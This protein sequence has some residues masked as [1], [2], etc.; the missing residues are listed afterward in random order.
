MRYSFIFTNIFPYN[1]SGVS[2]FGFIIYFMLQICSVNNLFIKKLEIKY[3][4]FK[5]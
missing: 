3:K 1:F 5:I 4:L 2:L